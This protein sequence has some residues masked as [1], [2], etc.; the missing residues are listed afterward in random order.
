VNPSPLFTPTWL[1]KFKYNQQ[2]IWFCLVICLILL[3][4]CAVQINPE[5]S[6]VL[7]YIELDN[8]ITLNQSFVS[9]HDGLNE[10][11]IFFVENA[12]NNGKIILTLTKRSDKSIP[13]ATS[14]F[15]LTSKNEEGFIIFRFPKISNSNQENYYFT[16]ENTGSKPV[17]IGFL[18]GES[19][20]DGG[21]YQNFE[22]TGNQFAFIL[23]YGFK[24]LFL[25]YVG[26]ILSW[27]V[28][29]LIFIILMLPGWVIM[30][31]LWRNFLKTTWLEQL[32]IGSVVSISLYTILFLWTDVINI[33]LGPLYVWILV[34]PSLLFLLFLIGKEIFVNGIRSWST[35]LIA[36]CSGK[37]N[38]FNIFL[39]IVVM[40]I[41]ISRFTSISGLEGPLWGDSVHHSVITQLFLDNK[42]IFSSWFPYANYI[43]FTVQYGFS[44]VAAIWAWTTRMDSIESTLIIGQL[45]NFLAIIS[46]FPLSMKITLGKRWAALGTLVIAGLLSPLPGGYLNWGRYAQLAG[47]AIL[48]VAIWMT[49]SCLD[50]Y[51]EN[52]PIKFSQLFPLKEVILTGL[53]I[54]AMTLAYYRTALFFG[55]FFV[56]YLLILGLSTWRNDKK[57]FLLGLTNLLLIGFI[58][59]VVFSPWIKNVQGGTLANQVESGIVGDVKPIDHV[60]ADYQVWKDISIYMPFS[61]LILFAISMLYSLVQRNIWIITL[62]I[63]TILLS[64]L[65]A[66][67]LLRLPT[68][69]FMQNFAVIIS[70]YI[71]ISLTCGWFVDQ[72]VEI[73]KKNQQAWLVLKYIYGLLLVCSL[74]IGLVK[75]TNISNPNFYALLTRPDTLAM[76]WLSEQAS[77]DSLVLIE[78]LLVPPGTSAVGTD[79]GWWIP[80]IARKSNTIPPQ[81]AMLNEKPQDPEY[82][83]QVVSLVNNLENNS[84]ASN[85]MVDYLC[86]LGITHIFIGQRQGKGSFGGSP[87]FSEEE[88]M[89]NPV[90]IP[91][92]RQDL[93]SIYS[94]IASACK[95]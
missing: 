13:L 82:N 70:L 79:A 83:N 21:M 4:G 35:Q 9:R 24:D 52:N 18:A 56:A 67:Q 93:V 3:T 61:L 77:E 45:F 5:K 29:F 46:L 49:W 94:L 85:E 16:L 14:E 31:F 30:R 2:I 73:S 26:V 11:Q 88:L 89:S 44:A 47:Q 42:G 10:I 81:Y 54:S 90:F 48:P 15:D 34:L 51:K 19:Y 68:A 41:F 57:A 1:Q 20:L 43:T 53:V 64:S 95:K 7:G 74:I 40:V 84:I 75:Q 69:N 62:G 78:G 86:K 22:P 60:I 92:Y 39:V 33:H 72:I 76:D 65:V 27:V 25:D 28:L 66:S 8:N 17:K 71:P 59:V 36:P 63:W 80:L 38:I 50:Y 58:S 23:G 55:T 87:L 12:L 6:D 32:S 91:L 37:N